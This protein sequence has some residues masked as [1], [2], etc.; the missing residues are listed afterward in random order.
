MAMAFCCWKQSRKIAMIGLFS[1]GAVVFTSGASGPIMMV[2]SIMFALA[3]WKVRQHL[4]MIRWFAVLMV[5]LLDL[6]MQDPVYYLVA[7]ID[8]TGGSTGWHRAALLQQA[9][10]HLHEWWLAGTD[11]TRHW[12]PTGIYANE[13]HTDITNHYLEN[14][15]WGGLPLMF[16]FMRVLYVAFKMVGNALRESEADT[17]ER[18]A[19]IW[20]LGSILFGHVTN[21][22][23]ISYFDQSV[24]FLYL[25]LACIASLAAQPVPVEAEVPQPEPVEAGAWQQQQTDACHTG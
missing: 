7:R 15:V 22:F 13:N 14:G 4:K 18:K 6:V 3:M 1:A 5:I 2:L 8:I 21:L 25:V 19:W 20:V 16:L 24:V 10:E 9:I 17:V 12:M 11:Y 23:S